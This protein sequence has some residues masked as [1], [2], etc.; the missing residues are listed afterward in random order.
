MKPLFL[1]SLP[2]SGSTLVQRVLASS[3]DVSTVPEPWLLLPLLGVRREGTYAGYGHQAARRAIK[4]FSERIEGGEEGFEDELRRF[5]R[6]LY[7]RA[8]AAEARYFLDKTP[9]YHTLAP[10]LLDLF[11][12]AK[13]IILW[14]NPLSIIASMIKT[15]GDGQWNLYKFRLDLYQGLPALVKLARQRRDEV[16]AVRYK[17]LVLRQSG[18]WERLCQHLGL[19]TD[20][21]EESP[22]A[23]NGWMG[24]PNQDAYEGIS[25]EPVEKWKNT[26]R[27]PLR[28]SWARRYLRWLGRDCLEVMGYSLSDL[29]SDLD[30]VPT[31][32]KGLAGDVYGFGIGFLYPLIEHHVFRDKFSKSNWTDMVSHY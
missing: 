24:D 18:V 1:F 32:G 14:R 25:S 5:V 4:E 3:P 7:D 30:K 22:P 12:E 15:W 26:I 31:T 17:D 19:K 10:N 21:L 8:A 27:N 13:A 11:P 23:L 2:R 6:R 28:K 29:E 9:R 16:V 20:I